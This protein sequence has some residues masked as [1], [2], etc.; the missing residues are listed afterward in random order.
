[1]SLNEMTLREKLASSS[2]CLRALWRLPGEWPQLRNAWPRS[3]FWRICLGNWN[4]TRSKSS[5]PFYPELLA[6]AERESASRSYCANRKLRRRP[7]RLWKCWTWTGRWPPSPSPKA[8]DQHSRSA[9]QLQSLMA[10]A[11][12]PEQQFLKELLLGGL[13]QGAL[14]GLMFEALAKASGASLGRIRRAAMMA[15]D[16]GLVARQLLESG[17]AKHLWTHLEHPALPTGSSDAGAARARCG[18]GSE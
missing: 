2:C 11:T 10:L 7:L 1:M 6:R 5:C 9:L 12:G 18:D 13:R 17:L 15:G 16:T 4:R 3:S 14:E 8:R